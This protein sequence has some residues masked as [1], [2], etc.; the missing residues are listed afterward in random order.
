MSRHCNGVVFPLLVALCLY[1]LTGCAPSE[2][3]DTLQPV[4]E[5][6]LSYAE[7]FS[8]TY[9]QDGLAGIHIADGTDYLLVPEGTAVPENTG[10]MVILQQPL[11]DLYVAASSAVDLFDGI[12]C[13]DTVTMVSTK[14]WSLPSVQTAL[15]DGRMQYVGK[16]SRP[17]Y[18]QILSNGC[19][20]AI[21]STMI[22]HSPETKEQLEQLGIPVLV[23]RSSYE[24]HPM[25]RMEWLRLYGLLLGKSEEAEAY[26]AQQQAIFESVVLGE[27]VQERKSVAFF[28]INRSGAVSIRKPGDYVARMIDMAGGQYVF[29]P[30]NLNVEENALSTMN[31]QME[32]FC[33]VARDADILIYNSSIEGE[34]DTLAQL[35]ELNAVLADFKAVR[36]GQVWCTGQNMFQQTTGAADMVSD[37][38][39]ILTGADTE[40]TYLHKLQ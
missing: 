1:L 26:F 2:T 30:E 28:Y 5:M 29:T 6:V 34:L 35:T 22:Y 8:I 20:L 4:G 33:E 17:D 15:D 12:G 21:E 16:Y 3:S 9:Y 36:E 37:F 25:G 10:N 18:E 39:A 32:T 40:L 38:H 23:E 27:D 19:D 24:T 11:G 13:L 7:Q 14:D 31:I